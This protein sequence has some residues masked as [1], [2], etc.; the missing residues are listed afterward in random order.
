MP[1]RG[2][3]VGLE[4]LEPSTCR[5]WVWWSRC[6]G[7]C[8]LKN[9]KGFFDA[10]FPFM[11]N[12]RLSR[13]SA[14]IHCWNRIRTYGFGALESQPWQL[15]PTD[16]TRSEPERDPKSFRKFTFG[17]SCPIWCALN[18]PSKKD[19]HTSYILKAKLRIRM[20]LFIFNLININKWK[21]Y[22]AILNIRIYINVPVNLKRSLATV[23]Y[24][25][26][27]AWPKSRYF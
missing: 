25:V 9:F 24:R 6:F 22:L 27:S 7:S 8:N 2:K 12:P 10:S 13:N 11:F 14:M 4:G 3:M 18:P 15:I 1:R 26:F 5:L 19:S 23:L 16:R 20:C 21:H 17:R